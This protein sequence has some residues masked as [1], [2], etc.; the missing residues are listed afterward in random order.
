MLDC[1]HNRLSL[2]VSGI[3]AFPW[4]GTQAG[5]IIGWPFP[6]DLLLLP[7]PAF[8]VDRIHF[9]S[10]V[11]WVGWCPCWSTGVPACLQ[12]IAS[13][14]SIFSMLESQLRS[15]PILEVAFI[16]LFPSCFSLS[17]YFESY[18]IKS[19]FFITSQLCS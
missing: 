14:G 5:L 9:G 16:Y 8:P 10:K 7:D 4:D 1:E 13:S 2:L 6:Q 12:E 18:C 15:P 19:W 17:V 3:G 11:L